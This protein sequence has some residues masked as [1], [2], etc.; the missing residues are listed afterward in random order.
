M[1]FFYFYR[2]ET[3]DNI[4][5]NVMDGNVNRTSYHGDYVFEDLQNKKVPR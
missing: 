5:F 1:W 2:D 3:Y 4:K